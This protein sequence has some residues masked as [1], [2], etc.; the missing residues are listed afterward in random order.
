MGSEGLPA[1][2]VFFQGVYK[3]AESCRRQDF[4]GMVSA[5]TLPLQSCDATITP[6]L[7]TKL[8]CEGGEVFRESYSSSDC[9][10]AIISSGF[11]SDP[12]NCMQNTLVWGVYGPMKYGCT[13]TLLHTAVTPT[14][15]PI[16]SPPVGLPLPFPT[17]PPT[18]KPTP[19]SPKD[20]PIRRSLASTYLLQYSFKS[21]VDCDLSSRTAS[22]TVLSLPINYCGQVGE[23]VANQGVTPV[24]EWQKL[25]VSNESSEDGTSIVYGTVRYSDKDC[26]VR[27]E[28]E[29]KFSGGAVVDR[30]MSNG[31]DSR[32]TT[33][34]T[35]IPVLPSGFASEVLYLNTDTCVSGVPSGILAASAMKNTE[36]WYG[37]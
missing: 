35:G 26:T 17:S 34:S 21:N 12:E 37:V 19:T 13:H 25:V 4:L 16:S 14:N 6:G 22:I 23:E 9:T 28:T 36:H 2:S 32:Y 20:I 15:K 18:A 5:Q 8:T 33:M 24:S 1:G 29:S 27:K 31:V 7:Y 10:G 30:C 3:D 11:I